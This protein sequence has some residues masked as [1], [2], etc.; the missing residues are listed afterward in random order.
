[1]TVPVQIWPVRHNPLPSNKQDTICCHWAGHWLDGGVKGAGCPWAVQSCLKSQVLTW[2]DCW[3]SRPLQ[4]FLLVSTLMWLENTDKDCSSQINT[5]ILFRWWRWLEEPSW[6]CRHTCTLQHHLLVVC[7][8]CRAETHLTWTHPRLL[9][10]VVS[11]LIHAQKLQ[12]VLNF[13]IWAAGVRDL[14]P[15]LHPEALLGVTGGGQV[16]LQRERVAFHRKRGVIRSRNRR[17]CEKHTDQLRRSNA[18]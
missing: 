11:A 7:S 18:V 2:Q 1:M 5:Y 13:I 17:L 15:V 12:P 8:A 10:S 6:R 3:C 9:H 4:P 16:A 14:L